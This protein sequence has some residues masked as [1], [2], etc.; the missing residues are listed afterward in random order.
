MSANEQKPRRAIVYCP[1]AAQRCRSRI[2]GSLLQ[3][4]GGTCELSRISNA[5]YCWVYDYTVQKVRHTGTLCMYP[6][7]VHSAQYRLNVTLQSKLQ[8]TGR[9]YSH[10]RYWGIL[11]GRT[12]TYHLSDARTIEWADL[13]V[14]TSDEP[15][16]ICGLADCRLIIQAINMAPIRI[17]ATQ[18]REVQLYLTRR[19][20]AFH[21]H[22]QY[23]RL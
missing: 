20:Q 15:P 2:G 8:Y 18:Y 3:T 23:T 9:R 12:L 13:I 10:S 6:Y 16:G 17:A 14:S 5:M 21:V 4:R 19:A 7:T 1:L 22:V 11:D